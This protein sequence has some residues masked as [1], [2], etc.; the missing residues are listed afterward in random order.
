MKQPTQRKPKIVDHG[1]GPHFYGGEM[2]SIMFDG[3]AATVTFG[4]MDT[5]LPEMNA[6]VDGLH[7]VVAVTG[8]VTLSPKAMVAL[9]N[10]LPKLLAALGVG[11]S[12]GG[13]I[14]V[15]GLAVKD[16]NLLDVVLF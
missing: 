14:L 9:A 8:R 16:A 4:H 1:A 3:A 10:Q 15:E 5:R 6:S 2:I 12:P 13:A 7:P 11:V